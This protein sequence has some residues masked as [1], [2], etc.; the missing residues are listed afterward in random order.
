MNRIEPQIIHLQELRFFLIDTT[1][2]RKGFQHA[3]KTELLNSLGW[4]MKK[5]IMLGSASNLIKRIF[6][7]KT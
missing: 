5:S 6:L 2:V 4:A 7:K 1:I 3:L